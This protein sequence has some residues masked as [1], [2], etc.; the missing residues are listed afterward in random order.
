[1]PKCPGIPERVGVEVID[2]HQFAAGIAD[3]LTAM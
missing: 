3:D 1:M 2:E